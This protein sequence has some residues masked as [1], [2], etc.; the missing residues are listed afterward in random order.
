MDMHVQYH[1]SNHTTNS[2][3]NC[4]L[5]LLLGWQHVATRLCKVLNHSISCHDCNACRQ[6]LGGVKTDRQ[7]ALQGELAKEAPPL[8]PPLHWLREA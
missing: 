3:P 6:M 2:D 7:T 8:S 1:W 5:Q 4:M